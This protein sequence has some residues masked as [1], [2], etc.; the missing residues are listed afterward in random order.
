[1]QPRRGSNAFKMKKLTPTEPRAKKSVLPTAAAVA[2]PRGR[3]ASI[4]SPPCLEK[5]WPSY[6]PPWNE[7]RRLPAPF[8]TRTLFK[9]T[10]ATSSIV[11][12]R[13]LASA[14][15]VSAQSK[16]APKTP[17]VFIGL[18]FRTKKICYCLPQLPDGER[19]TYLAEEHDPQSAS[20]PVLPCLC[21]QKK[22]PSLSLTSL[23]F[24][25]DRNKSRMHGANTTAQRLNTP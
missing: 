15:Q 13:A 23:P 14:Q 2:V 4:P 24:T 3:H 5:A 10:S 18:F 12:R 19:G 20:A 25:D 6:F 9:L 8:E 22:H 1:M 21:P 11:L 7:H 17:T 16:Q